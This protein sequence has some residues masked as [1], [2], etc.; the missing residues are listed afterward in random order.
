VWPGGPPLDDLNRILTH[1]VHAFSVLICS[2]V[3]RTGVPRISPSPQSKWPQ[4]GSW[5]IL[6]GPP[7]KVPSRCTGY[8]T[9]RRPSLPG[10]PEGGSRRGDA[11][12]S[13]RNLWI[14]IA[15]SASARCDTLTGLT[16]GA[17]MNLRAA[18]EPACPPLPADAPASSFWQRVL[19]WLPLRSSQL[20]AVAAGSP[21]RCLLTSSDSHPRR[22]GA[23]TGPSGR[24]EQ[25][26]DLRII[27]VQSALSRQSRSPRG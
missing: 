4:S 19:A 10:A 11:Y 20:G 23:S 24:N 14:W 8:T 18:R 17:S 27:P 21:P 9:Y 26:C 1:V 5:R 7:V 12:G 15:V 2:S 25:S 3:A 13:R 6:G 16:G 22:I